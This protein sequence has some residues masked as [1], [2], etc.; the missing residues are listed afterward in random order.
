MPKYAGGEER[1]ISV[2]PPTTREMSQKTQTTGIMC[3]GL[4]RYEPQEVR[5][6]VQD[7]IIGISTTTPGRLVSA[8]ICT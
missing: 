3:V 1:A 8:E 6:K 2:R 5:A 4:L 7:G